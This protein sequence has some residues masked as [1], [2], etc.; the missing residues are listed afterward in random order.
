MK[1]IIILIIF[2]IIL[3]LYVREGFQDNRET[4]SISNQCT[5]PIYDKYK[6]KDISERN[7]NY[8]YDTTV[9]DR[10]RNVLPFEGLTPE[11]PNCRSLD[12]NIHNNNYC[13]YGV[14][15]YNSDLPRYINN[16]TKPKGCFIEYDGDR[17]GLY[18]NMTDNITNPP[19]TCDYISNQSQTGADSSFNPSGQLCFCSNEAQ[20]NPAT[21]PVQEYNTCVSDKS[22]GLP[23]Y[24]KWENNTYRYT[25]TGTDSNPTYFNDTDSEDNDNR[26]KGSIPLI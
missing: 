13:F 19:D 24:W 6:C 22:M 11:Q 2:G 1:I 15:A 16:S 25:K 23:P 14:S 26:P 10:I 4:I 3:S 12:D 21:E 7:I 9:D 18:V 8:N 5:Y 17:P 20:T